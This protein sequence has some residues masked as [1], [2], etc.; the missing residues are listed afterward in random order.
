MKIEFVSY[1]ASKFSLCD[2]VLTL[3]IDGK[4]YK[5]GFGS[6]PF[7]K[8]WR[9]GGCCQVKFGGDDRVEKA[10]WIINPSMLPEK[11]R[12]YADEIAEIFNKNVPHGCCGGCL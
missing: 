12:D 8:F 1:E 9:S 7:P 2:G 11:L 6:A 3:K 5:F 4:E 10:P